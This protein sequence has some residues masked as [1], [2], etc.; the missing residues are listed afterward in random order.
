MRHSLLLFLAMIAPLSQAAD[1]GIELLSQCQVAERFSDTGDL[2]DPVAA[3]SCVALL[4]GVHETMQFLSV[5]MDK[6]NAFKSC[7]PVESISNVQ[8]MRIVVKFLRANPERLHEPKTV[9][10]I[11]ALKQAFPCPK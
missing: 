5:F 4:Q 8:A 1:T 7:F 6:P 10:A 9:L 2:R 11:L 3:M